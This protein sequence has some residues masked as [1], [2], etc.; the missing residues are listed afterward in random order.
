MFEYAWLASKPLQTFHPQP[1]E[2]G[3]NDVLLDKLAASDGTSPIVKLSK[4]QLQHQIQLVPLGLLGRG[5]QQ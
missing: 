1:V 3:V 2:A 4:A 5:R